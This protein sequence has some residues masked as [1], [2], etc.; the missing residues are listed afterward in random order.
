[1][2]TQ[3]FSPPGSSRCK[4]ANYRLSQRTCHMFLLIRLWLPRR[5]ER[6]ALAS[7]AGSR[8]SS[9]SC[10]ITQGT[11]QLKESEYQRCRF[12]SLFRYSIKAPIAVFLDFEQNAGS[13]MGHESARSKTISAIGRIIQSDV[14]HW[15]KA[16]NSWRTFLSIHRSGATSNC[17]GIIGWLHLW[18]ALKSLL[19]HEPQLQVETNSCLILHR[20]SLATSCFSNK[21]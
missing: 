9:F 10:E 14:S 18:N 2:L 7:A 15:R 21:F 6:Q 12:D 16:S 13:T 5:I 1:M 17:R 3:R 11:A 8:V 20:S 19:D 4:G